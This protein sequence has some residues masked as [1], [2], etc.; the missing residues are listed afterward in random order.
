MSIQKMMAFSVEFLVSRSRHIAKSCSSPSHPGPSGATWPVARLH[1][2]WE[3]FP[4]YQLVC[5]SW[6]C[7]PICPALNLGLFSF[8]SDFVAKTKNPSV[9]DARFDFMVG[10]RQNVV[11]PHRSN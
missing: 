10:D 3:F 4:T 11:L 7:P 5:D 1:S 6:S 2:H 8:V 9:Y